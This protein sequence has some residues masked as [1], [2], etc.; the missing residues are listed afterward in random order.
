M[1]TARKCP[2]SPGMAMLPKQKKAARPLFDKPAAYL[3]TCS[4]K[5]NYIID[6]REKTQK[7][8]LIGFTAPDKQLAVVFPR[9]LQQ[10]PWLCIP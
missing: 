9:L 2:E 4:L 7:Q 1:Q 5:T 3:S 10:R 8:R 6:I